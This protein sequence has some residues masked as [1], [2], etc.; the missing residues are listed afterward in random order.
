MIAVHAYA[1]P[2]TRVYSLTALVVITSYSIHYTKLYE[3]F[4]SIEFA[5]FL[6]IVFV[7]YWLFSKDQK[8]QNIIILISSYLFYGWWDWKFLTLI[9]FSSC[10]DF[11]IGILLSHYNKTK[12]RKRLLY[13]SILINIGLLIYFKYCNFFIS[14]FVESFSHFGY[15]INITTL[16]IILPVG[17]SFYTFQTLV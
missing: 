8:K 4:N 11:T 14:S 1:S 17:I 10:V 12:V 15:N 6:P 9:F 2:E 5:L 16:N 3:L 13:L 7:I